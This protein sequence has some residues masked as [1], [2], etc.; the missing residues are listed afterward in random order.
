MWSTIHAAVIAG[1]PATLRLIIVLVVIAALICVIG[2]LT[3]QTASPVGTLVHV[4]TSYLP[5]PKPR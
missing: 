3:H 1:W 4:L 5:A 2:L